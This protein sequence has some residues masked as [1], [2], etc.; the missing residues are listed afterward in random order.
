MKGAGLLDERESWMLSRVLTSQRLAG[1]RMLLEDSGVRGW[2][3]E[4]NTA[5][6]Q[7]FEKAIRL[8]LL[9]MEVVMQG[10]QRSQE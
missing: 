2:R 9:M 4:R 3:R 8:I 6:K 7:A 1:Q 5:L 10:S